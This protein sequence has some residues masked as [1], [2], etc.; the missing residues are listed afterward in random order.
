MSIIDDIKAKADANGDGK[1]D[2]KDLE[3]LRDGANGEIIDKLKARAMG[4]NGKLDMGD[5]K[6]L[7]LDNLK[8]TAGDLVD[9]AKNSLGSLF[10]KK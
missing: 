10:G 7:N 6:N 3:S 1:V 5:L 9:E 2:L 4:S 8:A